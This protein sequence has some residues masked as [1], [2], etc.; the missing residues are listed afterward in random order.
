LNLATTGTTNNHTDMTT[1]KILT[2]VCAGALMALTAANVNAVQFTGTGTG[3]DAQANFTISAGSITITLINLE[4]DLQNVGQCI[5]GLNFDVSGFSGSAAIGSAKGFTSDISAG[6]YTP[7]LTQT[8]LSH[9]GISAPGG[10]EIDLTT[11]TSMQP[12][13]LIAGPDNKGK[14]D[15]SGTYDN[16]NGSLQ[17]SHEPVVLGSA[18]F[19]ITSSTITANSTISDVI[20]NFGTSPGEYTAT[21]VPNTPHG[22]VPDGASTVTLLGAVLTGIGLFHKKL[23]KS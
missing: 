18:T 3:L 11:L 14:L 9:W 21:G 12:N 6:T 4:P 23:A 10:T 20:F 7:S 15:G 1:G 22:G 2:T 19:T 16:L 17:N 8:T 5:S 13:Q